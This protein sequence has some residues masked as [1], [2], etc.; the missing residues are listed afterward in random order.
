MIIIILCVVICVVLLF[1]F[2]IYCYMKGNLKG[3]KIMV[4]FIFKKEKKL[5]IKWDCHLELR[6]E[7]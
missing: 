4:L 1:S 3:Q 5:S 7:L 2:S 6:P